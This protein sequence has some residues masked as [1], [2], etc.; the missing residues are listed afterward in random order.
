MSS[1]GLTAAGFVKKPLEQIKEDVA[2]RLRA[3]LGANLN[4]TAESALGQAYLILC[5]EIEQLW[6]VQEAEHKSWDPDNS[7]G[8]ALDN[9][10]AIS[11][12]GREAAVASMVTGV[13]TGTPT[14]NVPQGSIASVSGDD[15]A[16]FVTDAAAVI[17]AATAWAGTTAYSVGDRVTNDS[18]I[19]QCTVAGTS[20][21]SGGPTGTG[22][23]IVDG[24]VTWRY[25]GDGTGYVDASMTAES[26]GPTVA[27][28]FTLTVIETPVS[29]WDGV[30]NP[31]DA[32]IGSDIE[33]DDEL[34]AR[35][36]EEL[37]A[38]GSGTVDS[39]RAKLLKVDDV[40]DAVVFENTS[41][42]TDSS[43]R[44]PHS[45]HPVVLGGTDADVAQAIWDA[46]GGGI[47]T[48]GAESVAATDSRGKSQTVNFDR[49]TEKNVYLELDVDII[50]DD[51][52][53]DGDTQL[54]TALVNKGDL[55][56]M[57]Q[58]VIAELLQSVAFGVSGV[59]DI[60]ELRLG[61]S[62]SPSGTAN[63]SIAETEIARFDT[64]RVVIT[65]NPVT[66]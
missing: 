21:G 20:A 33:T 27:N 39:I 56:T 14:T 43:G 25:L 30:T 6:E 50:S 31:L 15:D 36:E 10:S 8:E 2:T 53:S 5:E 35:R 49:A 12:T 37:D 7:T 38:I 57:G 61:F 58:D 23:D 9:V 4:L 46:A 51:Y 41:D 1:Y 52:P 16:R 13:L 3:A 28:A 24:T 66:P 19:Y 62:A 26:T 42:T 18:K 40:E 17:A 11:G 64:S 45:L 47:D 48:Y 34:R 55:L 22:T 60:T 32:V 63:L 65:T 59:Y 44:P 54:A 29:G